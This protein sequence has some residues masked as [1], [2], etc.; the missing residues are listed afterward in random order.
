MKRYATI[1]RNRGPRP[2]QRCLAL[3]S[4]CLTLYT[5]FCLLPAT[6]VLAATAGDLAP[7]GN[8]DG[9]IGAADVTVLQRFVLGTLT[10]TSEE[11]EAADVAPLGNP[12]GILNAADILLLQRAVIGLVV[13]PNLNYIPPVADAG[14][15]QTVT[16]G[17]TVNL[18]GSNSSDS[19]GTIVSYA[20]TQTSGVNVSLTGATSATAS[21]TAPVIIDDP[22]LT[23]RSR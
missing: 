8:P 14:P 1:R 11:F 6:H 15:D 7:R 18:D 10:P 3:R 12:D 23:F 5:I 17:D 22:L 19:D 16:E 4:L 21:F 13:L 20:W 2:W 9:Q